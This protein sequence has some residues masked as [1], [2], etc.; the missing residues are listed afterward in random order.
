MLQASDRTC[1][2]LPKP[3]IDPSGPDMIADAGAAL[4]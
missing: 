1:I 4:L 2:R 3:E